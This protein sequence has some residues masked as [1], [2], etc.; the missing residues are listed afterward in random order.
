MKNK[1]KK[2]LFICKFNRFRSKVA[3]AIFNKLNKKHKAKSAGII[4]GN[5]LDK[6]QVAVA[7]KMGVNIYSKP[8]GLT[9][10]MLGWADIHV[11]TADDIPKGILKDSEKYGKELLV[12]NIPDAKTDNEKEIKS[13]IEKIK[14]K[15]GKLSKRLK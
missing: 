5:P 7:K 4:R 3:E 15:V 14:F 10:K 13:I 11:I 1:S 2:I 6:L 9:S 12:W 8:Q